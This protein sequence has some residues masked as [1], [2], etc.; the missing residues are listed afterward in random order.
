[1]PY[2]GVLIIPQGILIAFCFCL[3][4]ETVHATPFR[5]SWLNKTT[6]RI[7]SLM[8]I[9]PMTW[10]QYFHLAHHRYTNES[11][12]DPELN[13]PKPETLR[14]YLWYA[15][16][17][18]AWWGNI[19]KLIKNALKHNNDP[20]IPKKAKAKIHA[21]A[22]ITLIIYGVLFCILAFGHTWLFW[23]WLLPLFLGQPFLRL[24]LLAEH[25]R[26]PMVANMFENTRTTFTNR[27]VRF[28][29]WNMP[30]HAE[31]HAYP[32]V[33]FHLL[34]KLHDLA[35]EYLKT[36]SAGYKKFHKEY[37]KTLRI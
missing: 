9:L 15:S 26:C 16:G 17:F 24:Y 32:T 29:A 25:G 2:W 35:K 22:R 10:F 37:Q 31:H 21:E 3:L 7:C 4:H 13:I 1:M 34:P 19:N 6:G 8:I 11:G 5:S 20:Y 33:P 12:K 30:Y 36:T 18:P 23:C 28:L 27:I 14:Q